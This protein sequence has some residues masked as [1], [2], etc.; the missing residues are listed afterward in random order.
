VERREWRP[1]PTRF[2]SSGITEAHSFQAG[3]AV[4]MNLA[5]DYAITPQ[6]RLGLAAYWLQQTTDTKVNGQSLAD[7]QERVIGYG[8]GVMYS[9]SADRPSE[10]ELLHRDRRA[11]HRRRTRHAALHPPLPLIPR[12]FAMSDTFPTQ[13]DRRRMAGLG[14]RAN[15][16]TSAEPA[17]GERLCR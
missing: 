11:S 14:L 9:F 2:A 16:S 12:S 10:P 17:T 4:H 7:T 13:P 15:G 6:L 8:P 5:T 3:Q 1:S